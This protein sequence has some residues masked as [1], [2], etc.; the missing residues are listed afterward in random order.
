MK[1]CKSHGDC[2][3]GA[4]PVGK[5]GGYDRGEDYGEDD[6]D[7]EEDGDRYDHDDD[8]GEDCYENMRFEAV[9]SHKL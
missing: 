5:K 8:H 9:M 7:D 3:G 2:P 6:H 1:K 4:A